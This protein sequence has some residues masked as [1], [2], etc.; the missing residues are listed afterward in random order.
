MLGSALKAECSRARSRSPIAESN[1]PLTDLT[2]L[3]EA[4]FTGMPCEYGS[5]TD[6]LDSNHRI[7]Y[8]AVKD[9]IHGEIVDLPG[10]LNPGRPFP[11]LRVP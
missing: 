8:S 1:E 2:A 11:G 10:T 6:L 9:L 3:T 4:F 5:R 7:F